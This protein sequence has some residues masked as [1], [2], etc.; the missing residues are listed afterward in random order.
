VGR[1]PLERDLQQHL[2]EISGQVNKVPGKV[3]IMVEESVK[4]LQHVYSK[5]ATNG[6]IEVKM[7]EKGLSVL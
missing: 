3:S 6:K 1:A 2:K 5:E 7:M 4:Y